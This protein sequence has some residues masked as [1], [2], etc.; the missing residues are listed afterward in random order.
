MEILGE[1]EKNPVER[2]VLFIFPGRLESSFRPVRRHFGILPRCGLYK[3]RKGDR[4]DEVKLLHLLSSERTGTLIKHGPV[5]P[6]ELHTLYIK[7]SRSR[8]GIRGGIEWK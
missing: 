7:A 6:Q 4:Q 5:F 8:S 1:I 3:N 2:L